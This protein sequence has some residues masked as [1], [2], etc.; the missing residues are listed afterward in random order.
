MSDVIADL[1]DLSG[2]ATTLREMPPGLI[3]FRDLPE[4][5]GVSPATAARYAKRLDVPKAQEIAGIRVWKKTEV[6][7]WAKKS[8]PPRGRPPKADT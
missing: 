7:R 6:Q 4:V 1:S 8:R 3:R 5:L 2:P